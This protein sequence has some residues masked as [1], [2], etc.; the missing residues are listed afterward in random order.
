MKIHILVVERKTVNMDIFYDRG[1]GVS[2]VLW[3]KRPSE[4]IMKTHES[5]PLGLYEEKS[6]PSK[7]NSNCK[8]PEA[9][10]PVMFKE[11]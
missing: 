2:K 7:E 10:L 4:K 1:N 3:D 11:Q 6:L 5:E 8:D 9:T